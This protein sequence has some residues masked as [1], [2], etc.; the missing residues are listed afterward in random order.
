MTAALGPCDVIAAP[1]ER[2]GGCTPGTAAGGSN[3][4][5]EQAER[6]VWCDIEAAVAALRRNIAADCLPARLVLSP[7][8]TYRLKG[9]LSLNISD[10]GTN[11]THAVEVR[12]QGHE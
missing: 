8:G 9:P 10:S 3:N 1:E 6:A 4:S 2:Q 5:S 11:A 12:E 7:G